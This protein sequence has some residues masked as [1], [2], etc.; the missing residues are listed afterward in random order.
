[1]KTQTPLIQALTFSS[2]QIYTSAI[3]RNLSSIMNE[4]IA[5]SI[6]ATAEDDSVL[7]SSIE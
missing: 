7:S 4:M 1:M 5:T 2:L 6:H 3:M